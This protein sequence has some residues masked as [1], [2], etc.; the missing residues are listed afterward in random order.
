[1]KADGRPG[2]ESE[3]LAVILTHQ[4]GR[5]HEGEIGAKWCHD[6]GIRQA[7]PGIQLSC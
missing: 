1:M 5:T 2:G 4:L 6:H 7:D 3:D